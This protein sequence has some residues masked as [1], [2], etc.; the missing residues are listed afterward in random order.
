MAIVKVN[1]PAAWYT[2]T[3]AANA[4]ELLGICESETRISFAASFEDVMTDFSGS[5]VPFDTQYMGEQATVSGTLILD[6][7][8]VYKKCAARIGPGAA[9][10]GVFGATPVGSIGTLMKTEGACYGLIIASPYASKAV[11]SSAGMIA[12][13]RFITAWLDGSADVS[14]GTRVTRKSVTFRATTNWYLATGSGVLFDNILPTLPAY[15]T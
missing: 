15:N 10:A 1:G 2:A 13:Y 8:I 6:N 11:F 9:T 7:D 5:G 4:Y 3:G 12:G 14:L